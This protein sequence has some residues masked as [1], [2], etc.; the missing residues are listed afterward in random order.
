MQ[1]KEFF[2]NEVCSDYDFEFN[3][4]SSETFEIF[5]EKE[6]LEA[7]FLTSAIKCPDPTCGEPKWD[8]LLRSG[9]QVEKSDFKNFLKLRSDKG[10]G[11]EK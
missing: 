7:K 9:T 5:E 11:F 8:N 3:V 1:I 10:S 2:S 4:P 6:S